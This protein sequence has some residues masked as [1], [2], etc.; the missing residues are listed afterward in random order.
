[1][2][3]MFFKNLSLTCIIIFFSCNVFSQTYS[4]TGHITDSKDNS[5]LIG[6]TV[7]LSPVN[8]S[9]Q[10]SGTATD[11]NGNFEIHNVTT[12]RY[13]LRSVYLGYQSYTQIIAI[14]GKN[15]NIGSIAM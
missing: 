8:D 7:I 2:E 4:V 11:A 12:G 3:V 6:V 5:S 10:K 13:Y 14:A 9:A 15:V 1:T